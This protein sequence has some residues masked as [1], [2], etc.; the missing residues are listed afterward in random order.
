MTDFCDQRG[1]SL[2]PERG[3]HTHT[4]GSKPP[5]RTT[6][7]FIPIGSNTITYLPATYLYVNST[8]QRCEGMTAVRPCLLFSGSWG[9]I[10][11][12]HTNNGTLFLQMTQM[13]GHAFPH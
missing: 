2:G 12:T 13:M 9:A 1:S 7:L 10:P 11:P 8:A 6:P 5:R 3:L 4:R